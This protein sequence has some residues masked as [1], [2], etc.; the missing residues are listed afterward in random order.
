MEQ[1]ASISFPWM[2]DAAKKGLIL[3][4]IHIF[5]FCIIYY[6]APSKLTGF[7][8]VFLIL[9][10]NLGYS[11]FNGIAYRREVGGYISLGSAFKYVFV[12]LVT[13][14]IIGIVFHIF[15]L[16]IEPAYPDV[17][18]QSQLDTSIYWAQKFNAPENVIEK[19]R[20]D[21]DFE[22]TRERFS[23]SGVLLSFGIGLIFSALG[24]LISGL[25]IR[26]REP[27]TV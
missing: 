22:G 18:T 16:F 12:L 25:I 5:I 21:F 13:N 10:L 19:M 20:D 27:E 8:Y 23:F 17:M 2:Q 15:F 1:N 4:I 9:V 26:K 11:I 24:A 3:G 14:G 7:S 6:L